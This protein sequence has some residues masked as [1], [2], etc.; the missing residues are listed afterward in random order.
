M[1]LGIV[2]SVEF[3]GAVDQKELVAY[4]QKADV[5]C[6]SSF[7]E[8]FPCAVVEA[9]ACG[10]PVVASQVGGIAEVVDSQSGILVPPGD[11]KLLSEALL[12]AK[13]R[14]WDQRMIRQR[15]VDGFEWG[16]WTQTVLQLVDSTLS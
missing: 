16:K 5:L 6:L 9:M 3:T 8:G 11:L 13:N 2:A 15:I 10:K 1:A 12:Q 4:Y 7:S 14:V